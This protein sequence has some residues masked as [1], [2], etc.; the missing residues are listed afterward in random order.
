MGTQ[1]PIPPLSWA[2][3]PPFTGKIVGGWVSHPVDGAD[4]GFQAVAA[5]LE[6]ETKV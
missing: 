1:P 5:Q 4:R 3:D 2:L 6:I